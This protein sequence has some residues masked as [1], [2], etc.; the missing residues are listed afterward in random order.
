MFYDNKKGNYE[1]GIGEMEEVQKQVID[2]IT[3]A[4]GKVILALLVYF[5]G[6]LVIRKIVKVVGGLKALQSQDESVRGIAL[7]ALKSSSAVIMHFPLFY[8]KY[9]VPCI[10]P[11]FYIK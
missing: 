9:C 3:N 11:I 4:G 1:R 2:L 7:K 6:R 5:I 10:F 8:S